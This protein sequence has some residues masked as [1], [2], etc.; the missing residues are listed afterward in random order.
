MVVRARRLCFRGVYKA[1]LSSGFGISCARARTIG[2]Q[3]LETPS[4]PC[5][6]VV[7]CL[8]G[9]VRSCSLRIQ[10]NSI[11]VRTTQPPSLFPPTSTRNLRIPIQLYRCLACDDNVHINIIF[12]FSLRSTCTSLRRRQPCPPAAAAPSTRRSSLT[13]LGSISSEHI[14]TTGVYWD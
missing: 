5:E 9:L 4:I 1:R 10:S 3:F 13:H 7:R 2:K 6:D 12:S 14:G 8:K 11:C